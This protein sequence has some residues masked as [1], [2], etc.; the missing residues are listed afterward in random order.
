M[1]GTS[2]I[3][4]RVLTV[5]IEAYVKGTSNY[6]DTIDTVCSEVETALGGSTING[7]VKDIYLV[8]KK[9]S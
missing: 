4:N 3:F 2:R 9:S 1:G 7:L 6:D 5:A 8:Y